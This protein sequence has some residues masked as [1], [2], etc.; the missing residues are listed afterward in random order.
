MSRQRH[1]ATCTTSQCDEVGEVSSTRARQP[2][3]ST[4]DHTYAVES[5]FSPD[6]ARFTACHE[7]RETLQERRSPTAAGIVTKNT[8]GVGVYPKGARTATAG[9]ASRKYACFKHSGIGPRALAD[10]HTR[11]DLDLVGEDCR[12]WLGAIR[13][14]DRT[15]GVGGVPLPSPV[16]DPLGCSAVLSPAFSSVTLTVAV[17]GGIVDIPGLIRLNP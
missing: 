14:G 1:S 8:T 13:E 4:S 10:A 2:P 6:A 17:N 16:G 11:L 3:D 5:C 7:N 12:A 15:E 9:E